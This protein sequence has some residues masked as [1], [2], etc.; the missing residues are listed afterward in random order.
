METPSKRALS[1]FTRRSAIGRAAAVGAAVSLGRLRAMAAQDA[2]P[3]PVQPP[4]TMGVVYGEADGTKLLLDIAQPTAYVGPRPAVV[5]IHGGGLMFGSRSDFFGFQRELADAGYVACSIEYRLFNPDTRANQWPAQLDDAQRAVRRIRA[6]D[7]AYGID[8]DW[9]AVLGHSSGGSLAAFLG[10]RDTRDDSDAALASFSSRVACV[11]DIAGAMDMT[12]PYPGMPID[13]LGAAQ[14]ATPQQSALIDFSP[15][16]FVDAKTAP[17]LILHGGADDL[18][19]LN[20]SQRMTETLQTAGVE[21]ILGVFPG[22]DHFSIADWKVIG[23]E[24]LA[25]LDRHVGASAS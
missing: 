22:L 13:A 5:L 14:G 17:F 3:P 25:F 21:V 15:Q 20:Q 4:F 24:A 6:N 12:K 1:G 2:T 9:I 7:A 16:T 11:V 10:N 19:P 23:P 18:C 8:P